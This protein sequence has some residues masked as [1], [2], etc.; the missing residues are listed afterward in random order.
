[1]G[2]AG[3]AAP[4]KKVSVVVP[5]WN[6]GPYI[7]PC[8]A[9]LIGQT[10]EPGAFEVILVDDGST[11]GT[12]ARLD[13]IAAEYPVIRVIH[14]P[15]SGWPGRPRNV[16]I[17][18]ARGEYI[19]FVDQD[20]QLAPDALEL[21]YAMAA[22]NRSDIVIGKV[23]G[24]FRSHAPI[25]DHAIRGVP[26]VLFR[27]NREQC[28]IFDAPLVDSLTPH[29]MFRAAFLRDTGI[30]FP[31]GRMR[32]EDQLFVVPAYF[33]ASVVSVL[34]D[35]VC[36][37][38]QERADGGNAGSVTIDPAAY[39]GDLR[40]VL[41][42]VIA[43]TEPGDQR[44]RLLRRF[45]R[46]EMLGRVSEPSFHQLDPGFRDGIY[47][48]VRSIAMDLID[49]AVDATFTPILRLRAALVRADR[50]DALVELARRLAPARAAWS[51]EGMGW[52]RGRLELAFEAS[53][54][55][56]TGHDLVVAGTGDA[57]WVL[58]PALTSGLLPEPFAVTDKEVRG[59]RADVLLRDRVTGAQWVVST[60]ST[61]E[62]VSD[63]GATDGEGAGRAA[64][65]VLHGTATL[66]P[67]TA[68][69]KHPLDAGVW[70]VWVRVVGLGLDR[71]VRATASPATAAWAGPAILGDRATPVVPF[72]EDDGGL[73]L[74]VG[75]QGH[76][77]AASLAADRVRIVRDGRRLVA[78]LPIGTS[79]ATAPRAVP[80][81]LHRGEDRVSLPGR[82]EPRAGTTLV[83]VRGGRALAGVGRG[84]W[85]LAA[86]FDGPGAAAVPLGDVRVRRFGRLAADGARTVSAAANLR[87]IL[88]DLARDIDARL[89]GV[90]RRTLRRTARSVR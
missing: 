1:M 44:T 7:D 43:N 52:T 31:E 84:R 48:A 78:R 51:L 4:V 36:Y 19:Q 33:A 89:P 6:P 30:R 9:S 50:P 29:K 56:A 68:A 37:L 39:Y 45:F 41:E 57:P 80:V 21:L 28:T 74:D 11:D 10:L 85:A 65:P 66:D 14:I 27:Q 61:L 81:T 63:A 25:G 71:T 35:H 76:T 67:L 23:A 73:S 16:G 82:L 62:G 87:W 20:D 54:D 72:V 22:R 32:L 64:R 83:R 77:V 58:D 69:G 70:D 2:S 86:E 75:A 17:E 88:G 90:L 5:V 34:G 12:G 53:F 60:K 8:I 24:S 18:A 15:N 13:A 47:R 55:T 46:V 42:I 40:A 26:Q 59:L 38:Y 49:P 3:V 79:A